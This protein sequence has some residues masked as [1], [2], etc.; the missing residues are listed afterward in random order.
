MPAVHTPYTADLPACPECGV[1]PPYWMVRAFWE[2]QQWR[3]VYPEGLCLE[4]EEGDKDG[5]QINAIEAECG[6]CGHYFH[7]DASLPEETRNF[8]LDLVFTF[9]PGPWADPKD[10]KARK[11]SS[12]RYG[13]QWTEREWVD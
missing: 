3:R 9:D 7:A 12:G 13:W 10:A 11:L 4:P 2:A 6:A 1:V 5:D 8:L